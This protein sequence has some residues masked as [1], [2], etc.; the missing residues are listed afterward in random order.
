M[1]ELPGVEHR[2]ESVNGIRMH[3]AEAG[4]GD[5]LVLLHG[6]PQHWWMWRDFIGPLAERFRV[7]APDLRGHGWSDKPPS[8]YLKTDMLADVLALLDRL[9]LDRVRWVGHDWGGYVG[10]LAGLH[11]PE[12]VERLVVMSIPHPWQRG[13][14]DPRMLLNGTYQLVVGGPLGRLA[15][16]RLNFARLIFRRARTAGSY[17]PEELEMFESVQ[18]QPD[19]ARATVQIYRS[20][21]LHELRPFA[22]GGLGRMRLTVPTL[23]LVGGNDPLAKYADEGYRDHADDM[24]LEC[25]PGASHFLPEELT[26]PVLERLLA[27]L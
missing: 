14:P 11:A 25:L 17:T 19:A 16:E 15:M 7:I 10:M 4:S 5:P 8:G 12:R 9:E 2:Y 6:W 22:R 18:R 26:Q 20:F 24:T 3:Y 27:F 13:L 21:M 1:P 23:W